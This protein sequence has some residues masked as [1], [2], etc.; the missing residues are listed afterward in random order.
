MPIPDYQRIM[1]PLLKFTSDKKEHTVT[2][3][4]EYIISYFKL[5]E[6][7]KTEKLPSGIQTII[8]NRVG[9]SR[10]YLKKAGLLDSPRRG[11]FKIT[12]RGL[13]VLSKDPSE[14]NLKT[15]FQ[16]E[17]FIEFKTK[18]KES[19]NES[20]H[21]TIAT[22]ALDPMEALENAYS[23][24]KNNL[25]DD[26]LREIK[27]ASP[28]FF[29]KAVLQLLSKMGYGDLVEHTGKTGDE[30]I[31]GK[32]REDKLG[33]EV[34]YVQAK[35]WANGTVGRPEIHKFIGALSSQGANKGIFI[36]T[37]SFSGDALECGL[38]SISPKI[39]LI[40]GLTLAQYMIDYDIG[41][42]KVKSFEIKRKDS[43]FFVEE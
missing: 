1:L 37:S 6:Q 33:L 43:D 18:H 21:Q 30:G 39:V 7:E 4:L 5:T 24:I 25:A 16:F 19:N 14:I 36:T 3:A 8:E 23:K 17:E 31:D 35:R 26:L 27:T 15:L 10:T 2:E 34:I 42:S 41:V 40:D 11:Y 9:W 12:D 38:K 32:I 20:I 29:E 13:Q 22:E 28:T